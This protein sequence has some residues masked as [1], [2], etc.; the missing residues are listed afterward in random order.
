V[1]DIKVLVANIVENIDDQIRALTESVTGDTPLGDRDYLF[2]AGEIRALRAA[3]RIV[4]D[5]FLSLQRKA[6]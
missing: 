3:R 5:E 2:Q 4:N 6:Q 1:I